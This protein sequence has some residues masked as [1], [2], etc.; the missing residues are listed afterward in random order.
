MVAAGSE[1]ATGC[2]SP[3]WRPRTA[4]AARS[5]CAA[6]PSDAEDVAAYGPVFD[7]NGNRLFELRGDRPRAR[8][9]ARARRRHRRSQCGR[10]AARRRAVRAPLRPA[11]TAGRTSSTTATSRA[12]TRSVA[13]G[14]RF[15]IVR[16]VDNFGAGDVIEVVADDGRRL[17]LP[18]TRRTVPS[19]DLARRRLVV[20]PPRGTRRGG[21]AVSQRPSPWTASVL[22][23]FPEMFPGPLGHSLAGRALRGGPLAARDDQP[24]RLRD[25]PASHRRRRAVRRRRRHGDA[26]GRGGARASTRR[27]HPGPARPAAVPHAARAPADP[28]TGRGACRRARAS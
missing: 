1:I 17:S 11:R 22:T 13:D 28:A 10:G 15:G 20:E 2:A 23:L 7:R 3:W 4:C 12:W 14:S 16:S 27:A 6:S 21:G 19:I 26:T 5:S 8:R 18:F 25:R 24:A 9:R